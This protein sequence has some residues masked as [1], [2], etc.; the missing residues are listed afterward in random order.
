MTNRYRITAI[1]AISLF[2]LIY[3]AV[4]SPKEDMIYLAGMLILF[5]AA[6]FFADMS[7]CF[8]RAVASYMTGIIISVIG[9]TLAYVPILSNGASVA[10]TMFVILLTGFAVGTML[11]SSVYNVSV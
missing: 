5:D 10:M 1:T 6:L 11:F 9:T 8:Y 3:A 2:L 7:N 4:S